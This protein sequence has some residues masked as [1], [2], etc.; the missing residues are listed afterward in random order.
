MCSR[1]ERFCGDHNCPGDAFSALSDGRFG[2]DR[3][4]D[5]SPTAQI[6]RYAGN[7]LDQENGM[8]GHG[9]SDGAGDCRGPNLLS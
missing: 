8:S 6:Q 2:S 9:G 4:S 5:A 3:A 7:T 1:L